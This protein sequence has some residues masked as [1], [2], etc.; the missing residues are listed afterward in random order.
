M[1]DIQTLMDY[2]L[3]EMKK[4]GAEKAACEIIDSKK[5]ELNIER[6]DISLFRTVYDA[7]VRL[8]A[9]LGNRKGST[10]INKLERA[11]IDQAIKQVIELAQ[12][13]E[14]DEAN[15]IAEKQ[16][17]KTFQTGP[18]EKDT[19]GMY[20]Q[21][22]DFLKYCKSTYPTLMLNE[23]A[24]DYTR[25]DRYFAN[26][27]GVFF[28]HEHGAYHFSTL[29][30]S[31]ENQHSSSFNHC[32][33]A[34]KEVATPLIKQGSLDTILEQNTRQVQ[35][36][37]VMDNFMGDVIITPEC[38][39]AFLSFITY[40]SLGDHGLI[41]GSSIFK[42]KLEKQITD[43][44][45]TVYAN[46]TSDQLVEGYQYTSDGY[47]AKDMTVID[48][49]VLKTFLLTLYGARKTG[50]ERSMNLGDG[51]VVEAGNQPYE[52]MI[53]EIKRGI[54]LC[55][56]S[57]GAPND[58]GDFSGIAKNSFMIEDGTIT[59][60]ISETMISGN[61]VQMFNH[62]K[63]ISTERVNDGYCLFPW[64][65]VDGVTISGK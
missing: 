28:T 48:N 39:G 64:I 52:S 12:S 65:H 36:I 11:S 53:R 59:K 56:F 21:L 62:I 38:L 47:A 42:D 32:S 43:P 24:T 4:Q 61:I 44:A 14:P 49:G 6:N 15:D 16:P 51:F 29:F 30:T 34:M 17:S 45:L 26:S 60:P 35:T 18:L 41:T 55:R 5:D 7:K 63:G 20:S 13:S 2:C 19:D 25:Q 23:G 54:L 22:A 46:P 50:R 57:G 9:I 27:N 31:K 3:N 40:R 37:P 8:S 10:S 33:L 58:N 1:E